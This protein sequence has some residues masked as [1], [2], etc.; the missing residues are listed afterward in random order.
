M[1]Y[2]IFSNKQFNNW[3]ELEHHLDVHFS[4]KKHYVKVYAYNNKN[5]KRLWK[6]LVK[7]CAWN[8]IEL[9]DIESIYDSFKIADV[10]IFKN[11]ETPT[12]RKFIKFIKKAYIKPIIYDIK[13]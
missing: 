3:K 10:L 8:N 6:M 4:G 7:Y 9:I 2:V 1:N 12:L 13:E 11:K 5:Q